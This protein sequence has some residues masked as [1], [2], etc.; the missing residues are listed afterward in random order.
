[1]SECYNKYVISQKLKSLEI[2]LDTHEKRR[3]TT[4]ILNAPIKDTQ[5]KKEEITIEVS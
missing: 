2:E 5:V 3:G 4:F 1:M